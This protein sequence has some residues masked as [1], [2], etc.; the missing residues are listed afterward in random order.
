MNVV[1]ADFAQSVAHFEDLFGGVFMKDLD[2]P[3]WHAYLIEI[4]GVI[5]EPFVPRN[6]MLHG[7]IGPHYLG[8]EYEADMTEARAVVAE[9]GIRIMRDIRDAFHTDPF[10]GFGVDYEFFGETFYGA[11]A[12]HV[13]TPTKPIGH[14]VDGH[15][16]GFTGLSG[17]THAV[18]DIEAASGFLQGFLGATPV[19]EADRPLLGARSIGLRVADDLVQLVSPIGPGQLL[20]E[21]LATGQGIRSTVFGVIDLEHARRH[22]IGRGLELHPGTLPGSLAIDPRDNLG[23][24][25]EF[26]EQSLMQ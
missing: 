6:F 5:F 15:P 19:F 24:R 11:G 26:V 1:V 9:H 20:D 14:W 16:V 25:F 7:R 13:T 22:F 18:A 4:G 23:L 10:D 21:M 12:K 3:N 8:V 17:Y 2:G